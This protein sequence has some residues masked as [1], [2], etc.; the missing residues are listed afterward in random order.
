VLFSTTA[1]A[2][3]GHVGLYSDIAGTNPE[4]T[5]TLSQVFNVYVVV[6]LNPTVRGA[7]FRIYAPPTFSSH[8]IFTGYSSAYSNLGDPF[9]GIAVD[10]GT[11]LSS[12]VVALTLSF[13]AISDIACE[14]LQVLG[15]P[16]V[17]GAL[18]TYSCTLD[19]L[20]ASGGIGY[21]STT[22]PSVYNRTP[23]DGA[24]DVPTDVTLLWNEAYCYE[25]PGDCFSANCEAVY[26]GT[27]PDPPYVGDAWYAFDPGPLQPY[28]TYYWKVSTEYAGLTPVWSF[29]TGEGPVAAE[30]ST[31]GQVKALYR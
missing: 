30:H 15:D 28:T 19:P 14:Q 4:I 27:D 6:T 16:N 12:P 11:C 17:G 23:A 9:T 20:F 26:L 13:I 10:F 18:Y 2:Q 31:W 21:V 5:P 25:G 8:V 3:G 7:Q 29:T 22:A 1:W 24:T